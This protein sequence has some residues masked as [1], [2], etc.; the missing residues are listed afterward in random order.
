MLGIKYW[1]VLIIPT[2]FILISSLNILER[3]H[4][5][6]NI[7]ENIN[8]ATWAKDTT[9]LHYVAKLAYCIISTTKKRCITVGDYEIL[10]ITIKDFFCL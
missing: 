10:T 6:F 4:L 2:N 7:I 9:L 1:L 5:F 3:M 8:T